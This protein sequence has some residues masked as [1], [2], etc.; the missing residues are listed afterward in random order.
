MLPNCERAWVMPEKIT[1]YLLSMTHRRGRQKA[2][3][4]LRFGFDHES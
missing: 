4:F 3:F 1:E 2:G